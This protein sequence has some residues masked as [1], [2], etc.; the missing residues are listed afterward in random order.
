MGFP[1]GNGY[2]AT[3]EHCLLPAVREK[4]CGTAGDREGHLSVS[5]RPTIMRDN[6]LLLFLK[7]LFSVVVSQYPTNVDVFVKLTRL[8]AIK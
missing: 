6:A 8:T 1:P 4:A 3:I 5:V 7:A 2:T